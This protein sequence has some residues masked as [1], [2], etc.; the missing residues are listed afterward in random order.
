MNTYKD[1][2]TLWLPFVSQWKIETRLPLL[3]T[4]PLLGHISYCNIVTPRSVSSPESS[5]L[6][7]TTGKS[8]SGLT[9]CSGKMDSVSASTAINHCLLKQKQMI[10]PLFFLF[11]YRKHP[12]Y[13]LECWEMVINHFVRGF[14][15]GHWWLCPFY[16]SPWS[17]R[18]KGWPRGER[19]ERRERS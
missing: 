6:V 14:S 3:V 12:V 18:R 2:S 17:Q 7:L 15:T 9:T 16:R 11:G 5:R 4:S 1:K 8:T 19:R 13:C 10:S